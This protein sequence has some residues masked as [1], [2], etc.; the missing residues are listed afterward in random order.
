MIDYLE[1][2]LRYKSPTF[3]VVDVGGVGYKVNLS[4][5]SYN[6][7]PPEGN[8]IKIN[9]YLHFRED[10]LALYGF[11]AKE[12]RDFFLLLISISKIGPKS[13]LRMLSRVSSSEL[14]KAIKRGD[15]TTLTDIPGIGKKTAQRLIL[16]LKE[17]IG[18]EEP[19]EPGK[20]ELVKDAL[21]ALVSLG[22]TQNEARKAV[23]EVIS[24]SKEEMDLTRVIKEA[25]NRV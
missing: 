15:L 18:E 4:L 20:E 14:K 17:R 10:G 2:I 16:E 5:S 22:Y 1:G 23:R 3:I 24:S 12:E 7:L 25:L 19:L 13:A 21:S 9:T 6:L 8:Q 11:L